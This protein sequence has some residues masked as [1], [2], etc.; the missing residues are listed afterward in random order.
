MENGFMLIEQLKLVLTNFLLKWV[1]ILY[2]CSDFHRSI[3]VSVCLS[4]KK[5]CLT[6]NWWSRINKMHLFGFSFEIQNIYLLL[7][8]NPIPLYLYMITGCL[9]I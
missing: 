9:R 5:N 3:H 1:I 6:S 2:W 7:F 4:L 8:S